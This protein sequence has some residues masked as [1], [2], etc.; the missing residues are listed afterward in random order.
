MKSNYN[1]IK[2]HFDEFL[3][4][5]LFW[6][7]TSMFFL[8]VK[9]NDLSTIDI[10]NIYK[11]EPYIDKKFLYINTFIISF[12]FGSINAYLHSFVYN[13]ILR[14]APFWKIIFIRLILFFVVSLSI[15]VGIF[16]LFYGYN[17]LE[18]IFSDHRRTSIGYIG[19]YFYWIFT[20]LVLTSILQLRRSLG[21]GFF[22]NFIKSKYNKP[23]TEYRIFMF[24]D[25][26]NSTP[27]VEKLGA[28]KFSS[29]I[30]DCFLI[31][32]DVVIKYNGLIYQFVGDEA[33][34]NWKVKC[35]FKYEDCLDL[36]FEFQK[37]IDEQEAYFL[38]KYDLKPE[39][40]CSLNDGQVSVAFVGDAKREIAFHGNVLNV[41]SR[42]QHLAKDYNTNMIISDSFY[43]K[44]EEKEKYQIEK[45]ENISLRGVHDV[46]DAYKVCE[47][48]S[49]N[50]ANA[51]TNDKTEV[52]IPTKNTI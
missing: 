41:G 1:T 7:V 42:L 24:L 10:I 28:I 46:V 48:N 2:Y 30:Q 23:K 3:F 11:V 50:V 27:T 38:E 12:I 45:L 40:R 22:E 5:L 4:S 26:A 51:Y 29:Y 47:K 13:R 16:K 21:V 37:K 8:F 49:Y 35:K 32:S 25:L 19:F 52:I 43:Q 18:L 36:Y 33:V 17:F 6:I 9:I 39:F 31:L 15:S 14:N 44:L 20:D 34:I